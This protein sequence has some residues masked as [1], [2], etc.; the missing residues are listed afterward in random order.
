M[1]CSFRPVAG[2]RSGRA[3]VAGGVR[4]PGRGQYSRQSLSMRP[5]HRRTWTRPSRAASPGTDFL[6]ISP[7]DPR[8]KILLPFHTC[9]VRFDPGSNQNSRAASATPN[10][11]ARRKSFFRCASRHRS[12]TRA[13]RCAASSIW[14]ASILASVRV[15]CAVRCA[16]LMPHILPSPGSGA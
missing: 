6:A 9:M 1:V 2:V 5:F 11:S 16:A 13:D 10:R 15:W 12:S 14:S 3:L 4:R 8:A 7:F